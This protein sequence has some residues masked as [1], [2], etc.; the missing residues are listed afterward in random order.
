M[1]VD[2]VDDFGNLVLD[3]KRCRG[4]RLP[5]RHF[6]NKSVLLPRLESLNALSLA[7]QKRMVIAEIEY[8][9]LDTNCGAAFAEVVPQS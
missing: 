2:I 3:S 4:I 8:F 7:L 5:A 9:L 6:R 1:A